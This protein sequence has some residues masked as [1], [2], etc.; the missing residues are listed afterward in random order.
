MCLE[1]Y[2][3]KKHSDFVCEKIIQKMVEEAKNKRK[4]SY[5]HII[6]KV[7]FSSSKID[8]DEII[9][10]ILDENKAVYEEYLTGKQKALDYL[11]GQVMRETKGAAK[12]QE[13]KDKITKMQ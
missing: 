3:N 7:G 6:K 13:V 9:K 4:S 11:V 2:T 12:P 8:I 10:K 5:K 1:D